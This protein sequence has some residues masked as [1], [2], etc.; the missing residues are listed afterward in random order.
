MDKVHLD[1]NNLDKFY[2]FGT[3]QGYDDGE[4][5]LP[6]S[7]VESLIE[8]EDIGDDGTLNDHSPHDPSD[9]LSTEMDPMDGKHPAYI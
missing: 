3:L 4:S 1:K 7:H 9:L 2:M 6:A 8:E 5:S